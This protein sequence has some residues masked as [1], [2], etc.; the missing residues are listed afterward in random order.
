MDNIRIT[1]AENGY[2]I[3]YDDPAIVEENIKANTW[4]DPGTYRVY[5]TQAALM[6]DLAA[7]LPNLKPHEPDPEAERAASFNDA[8]K[9]E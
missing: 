4:K 3:E 5:G 8:F 1:I 7:L 9:S 6:E 2:M